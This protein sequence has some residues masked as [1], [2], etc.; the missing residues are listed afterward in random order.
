MLPNDPE[1]ICSKKRL[2]EGIPI[3]LQTY[4]S[5]K[6]ISQINKIKLF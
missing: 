6:K 4:E 1:I 3:D 2:K 5:I